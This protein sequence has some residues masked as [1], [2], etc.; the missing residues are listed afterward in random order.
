MG[1]GAPL[2]R[3]CACTGLKGRIHPLEETHSSSLSEE[4]QRLLGVVR[5]NARQMAHLIDDLLAFSRIGRADLAISD[6]DM[7]ELAQAVFSDLSRLDG[8]RTVEFSVG[9]L[10]TVPADYA[11]IRQV[12]A[13]LLENSLKFTAG[14]EA[15]RIEIDCQEEPDHWV[16]RVRDNGAGFDMEYVDKLFGVFQ[17]LHY[18]DEFPGTGVG[19]ATVQRIVRRHGGEVWAEGEVDVGATIFFRL[20][21][22]EEVT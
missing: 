20:P 17:R 22:T 21:R 10:P 11:L 3:V 8:D 7:R 4:G 6:V 13:N 2:D 18:Q 1:V 16:F 14:R 12:W 19:L 5:E 15:A 9:K